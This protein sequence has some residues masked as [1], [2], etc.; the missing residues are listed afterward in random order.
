MLESDNVL[1]I[2]IGTQSTRASIVSV[3]GTIIGIVQKQHG[4]D[5]PQPGWAQQNPR[6]WWDE[7]CEAIRDVLADTGTDPASIAAIASCGQMH[8][9]VGIDADGNVTNQWAQLWCDKRTGKQVEDILAAN[10]MEHLMAL[11]GSTPNTA[12]IG[13]KVRW[14][15]DNQPEVY[16]KS[17]VFL[18]P[19][20][21]INYC[22]TG[23]AAGDHSEQ[24]ASFL[25][26]C[27][28]EQ[29]SEELAE[30]VGVDLGKFPEIHASDEVI[31]KVTDDASRQTGLPSGIPVVAGAGDFPASMLGFGIVGSDVTADV[32]GTSTLVAAHSKKPLLA[33]GIQNLRHAVGGWIPFTVLDCGGMSMTWCKDMVSSMRGQEVSYDELIDMARKAPAGSDGLLF[34]PYMLGERRLENTASRGGYFGLTLNHESSH[35]VRSVMEGVALSMGKDILEFKKQGH[36][37]KHLMSVGGGT[38]NELWNSIKANITGVSLELSEEPEA[39]IKGG[40]LLAA[41]GVGLVDDL[42]KTSVERR[43]NTRIIEP[44]AELTETY[45]E[46]QKEYVRVYEHMLGFWQGK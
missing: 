34:Y 29:Y 40:A 20:D 1:A 3:D 43:A 24:S 30:I 28:T 44:D 36:N 10:D 7:A 22:L 9:P 35:F 18:V 2:D 13:I 23:V 6:T 31:G 32:T 42:V 26:D 12:W 15:K 21:Y 38:R 11:A 19:K 16:D 14:I 27:K 41:S 17:R 33:P 5:S 37:I 4:V 46:V 8:A 45:R 25:Y 39:G